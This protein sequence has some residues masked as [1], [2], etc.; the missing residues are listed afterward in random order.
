MDLL[1]LRNIVSDYLIWNVIWSKDKICSLRDDTEWVTLGLSLFSIFLNELL[2]NQLLRTWIYAESWKIKILLKVLLKASEVAVS[3]VDNILRFLAQNQEK[4][5]IENQQRYVFFINISNTGSRFI[6]FVIII[7]INEN[8][9]WKSYL[10]SNIFVHMQ[11]FKRFGKNL[12]KS[13]A[14]CY[15]STSSTILRKATID[16]RIPLQGG[17]STSNPTIWNSLNFNWSRR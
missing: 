13:L 8:Q 1:N 15:K 14:K 4:G 12:W 17:K 16:F 6:H 7:Y 9:N 3:V 2:L 10:V 5:M 11:I